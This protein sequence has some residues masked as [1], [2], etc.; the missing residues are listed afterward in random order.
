VNTK[1]TPCLDFE[2]WETQSL[3]P[4]SPLSLAL[5]GTLKQN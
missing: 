3:G 2:T 1:G 4:F 5:D